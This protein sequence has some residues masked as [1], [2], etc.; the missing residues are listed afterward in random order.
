MV[1]ARS[2]I[3]AIWFA[4]LLLVSVVP[5]I[6]PTAVASHQD[7][8]S[9]QN[10]VLL[11]ETATGWVNYDPSIL[12]KP[13]TKLSFRGN[14][15]YPASCTNGGVQPVSGLEWQWGGGAINAG[16][17]GG[18]ATLA[19]SYNGTDGM[20]PRTIHVIFN[21]TVATASAANEANA[22]GTDKKV[23]IT[24]KMFCPDDPAVVVPPDAQRD[25]ATPHD[26][27]GMT[28]DAK[29]PTITISAQP[30]ATMGPRE[31]VPGVTTATAAIGSDI[32]LSVSV[33]DAISDL[34]LRT[35]ELTGNNAFVP[36]PSPSGTGPVTATATVPVLEAGTVVGGNTYATRNAE[37]VKFTAHAVDDAG[38]VATDLDTSTITV[39]NVRPPIAGNFRVDKAFLQIAPGTS[40]SHVA[41]GWTAT[42]APNDHSFAKVKVSSTENPTGTTVYTTPVAIPTAFVPFTLADPYSAIVNV[43]LHPIDAAGNIN[44]AALHAPA[45]VQGINVEYGNVA[46]QPIAVG[47]STIHNVFVN[48]TSAVAPTPVYPNYNDASPPTPIPQPVVFAQFVRA[49]STSDVRYWENGT[50]GSSNDNHFQAASTIDTGDAPQPGGT[51]TRNTAFTPLVSATGGT[52]VKGAYV[53]TNLTDLGTTTELDR[54]FLGGNYQLWI[55]MTTPAGFKTELRRAFVIDGDLPAAIPFTVAGNNNYTRGAGANF[56]ETHG[57]DGN[58]LRAYYAVH[59]SRTE[60]TVPPI[61]TDSRLRNVT[62]ELVDLASTSV[63]VR[64]NAQ[65]DT[66]TADIDERLARVD[67]N[68]TRSTSGAPSYFYD[69]R[70]RGNALPADTCANTADTS[71]DC[72]WFRVRAQNNWTM[73]W[74]NETNLSGW[75]NLTYPDLPSGKFKVRILAYDRAGNTIQATYPSSNAD[76]DVFKVAPAVKVIPFEGSPR[77][78]ADNK[79]DVIVGASQR[80][81]TPPDNVIN[82]CVRDAGRTTGPADICP[83]S[84]VR[85]YV[86]ATNSGTGTLYE[87]RNGPLAQFYTG[88]AGETDD[89]LVRGYTGL[90]TDCRTNAPLRRGEL[91]FCDPT[92]DAGKGVPVRY[93]RYTSNAPP[94]IPSALIG[95]QTIWVKAEAIALDVNGNE[96]AK[97]TTEWVRVTLANQASISINQPCAAPRLE[98]CATSA[99]DWP[100]NLTSLTGHA[101][102]PVNISFDAKQD[103]PVPRL[104]YQ[105]VNV[106]TGAVDGSGTGLVPVGASPKIVF[107]WQ[108][109]AS[110]RLILQKTAGGILDE[111]AYILKAEIYDPTS[112]ATI[113]SAW[114]NFTMLTTKPKVTVDPLPAGSGAVAIGPNRY[115]VGSTF[116]VPFTVVHNDTNLTSTSQLKFTLV[117]AAGAVIT[118]SVSVRTDTALDVGARESKFTATITMPPGAQNNNSFQLNITAELDVIPYKVGNSSG[119]LDLVLDRQPPGGALL[120]PNSEATVLETGAANPPRN[121]VAPAPAFVG[122]VED[123]AAGVSLVEI[124]LVDETAGR[125]LLLTSATTCTGESAGVDTYPGTN[126]NVWMNNTSAFVQVAPIGQGKWSWS[127]PLVNRAPLCDLYRHDANGGSGPI[128]L[129]HK[130]RV[131]VRVTDRL[132]QVTTI[133]PTTPFDF[134]AAAPYLGY[135]SQL[136][137]P[138]SAQSGL[139]VSKKFVNW[140]GSG[141]DSLVMTANVT[142]NHCI[143]AVRLVGTSEKSPNV[144]LKSNMTPVARYAVGGTTAT[145]ITGGHDRVCP[146][147]TAPG[148]AAQL[149]QYSIDLAGAV[150]FL[151]G[152]PM[153]DDVANYTFWF[154]AEDWAGQVSTVEPGHRLLKIEVLDH[155]PA[156]VRGIAIDPPVGQAGGRAII[157]ADVFDNHAISHVTVEVRGLAN[158]TV[159]ARTNMTKENATTAGVGIW[160]ADT[161]EDLGLPLDVSDY[162]INVT[163]Y[164]INWDRA[165]NP[166]CPTI[167]SPL[168]WI[169]RVRDDGVPTVSADS[170]SSGATVN[171]TPILK[172]RAL[173]KALETSQISVRATADGNASNLAP[174]PAAQ[175]QFTELKAANGARQGWSVVYTPTGV[176]DNASI[177]VNVTA[178]LASL[179]DSR[180]FTYRVDSLPPTAD[181]N[182]T[183]T[184]VIGDKTFAVRT[185]RV[186]LTANDTVSTPTILYTV[187]GGA[188]QTYAGEITPS[189]QD[190]EWKL[191]YWATDPAGNT[192]AKKSLTLQLDLTGPRITVAKHGDEVL[193]TVTDGTGVG[194]NESSVTVQYRYGTASAFTA[195][196]A[197]K[198]TGNSFGT[199]LPGNA[200]AD[201]LAYYF[202][203]EDL[204][205][206]VGSNFTAAQPY[207]IR[208]ENVTPDNLAPTIRITAP[209][210]GT[211]ARGAVE[212]RWLAEDP[213]EAPL[214]IS[215]ALREPAPGRVLVPA[216]ENSGTYSLN[217]TGFAAGAYTVVVTAN[218]G[219]HSASA[220]IT[221]NVE[222]VEPIQVRNQPP[223]TVQPNTQVAVAVALAPPADKTVAQATYRVLKDGQQFTAG[224]LAPTQGLYAAGFTPVD[225]GNYVVV[226]DVA[227]NDNTG[228][229]KQVA[230]FSVPGTIQPPD[231]GGRGLMPTSLMVLVA[232][233]VL[234]VALAAYGAFGRWKK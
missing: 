27:P 189:G 144:L 184:R 213:E 47:R 46:G 7:G 149:I 79:L 28:L 94:V 176:A 185:T 161:T 101:R 98:D 172:F 85:L 151:S 18:S 193:L 36:I 84:R 16:I 214:T 68:V 25:V 198:L 2:R 126:A 199:T 148:T 145:P 54:Q 233:A 40:A 57:A 78:T 205:G 39:D 104:R 17:L 19:D 121:K 44:S 13:A 167:C 229:S 150:D 30:T 127:I 146:A 171:A 154:E 33:N 4:T 140:H 170:P 190:G 70:G 159:L 220:Q 195:K 123:L 87:E 107:F 114:R 69:F 42:A 62:F 216:G 200:T 15:T 90:Y 61:P 21:V 177:I 53:F 174:V 182:A 136:G 58:P 175:L 217:T 162:L 120:V 77:L 55:N 59:D 22:E 119:F 111:G 20:P 34:S 56:S 12:V 183:N 133:V 222:N 92:V 97:S 215:I 201:G 109:A 112:G 211:I 230:S 63:V 52:S 157:R 45:F 206:N 179:T 72:I 38:N 83:A 203:A 147:Q 14:V 65:D 95:A 155:T 86:S 122:F 116:D 48:T 80:H 234:T 35:V 88:P 209:A 108:D 132:G 49:T 194:L 232:I 152:R 81:V 227:Y 218:D 11:V 50:P 1:A 192:A 113:A 168:T 137:T 223:P 135:K 160:R 3:M 32:T 169:Y 105:I 6:A 23:P 173:H 224:R 166:T 204:L 130:Y 158:N 196:K 129:S 75:V 91:Q 93:F 74:F 110:Q 37:T 219:E 29:K 125:T 117:P 143:K 41:V 197:D 96:V 207:T 71:P 139:V 131:D 8:I 187:N 82:K 210:A 5:A 178:S 67:I 188:E 24:I 164:D 134:D 60:N 103:I 212:L 73:S 115:V 124:R 43:T 180:Q 102:P 156:H 191:E 153:T 226:V 31:N 221:F 26:S 181:A 142:D 231:T 76:A 9:L 208:K 100:I 228:E 165:V 89:S 225:P 99:G 51:D 138:P 202:T 106:T 141:G 66:T 64:T 118:P 163:A 10:S 128:N 186:I